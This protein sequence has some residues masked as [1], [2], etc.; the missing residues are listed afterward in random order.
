MNRVLTYNNTQ[1][2]CEGI[3][4][5][6]LSF[7]LVH[8]LLY[9]IHTNNNNTPT[10]IVHTIRYGIFLCKEVKFKIIRFKAIWAVFWFVFFFRIYKPAIKIILSVNKTF[11]TL[12]KIK[13]YQKKDFSPKKIIYKNILIFVQD[14]NNIILNYGH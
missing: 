5:V 9:K 11:L 13:F 8:K 6:I 14:N 7:N 12:N 2:E 1:E 10:Y 3:T 4:V